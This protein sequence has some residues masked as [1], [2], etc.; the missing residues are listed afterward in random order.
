M[1]PFDRVRDRLP[2]TVGCKW[3]RQR[4]RS[5]GSLRKQHWPRGAMGRIW[6]VHA[7]ER[8]LPVTSKGYGSLALPYRDTDVGRESGPQ[9]NGTW[10]SAWEPIVPLSNGGGGRRYHPRYQVPT[11]YKLPFN[12]CNYRWN[13]KSSHRKGPHPGRT[14][15][16]HV[17]TTL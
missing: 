11:Q 13:L 10:G 9:Q 2:L 12:E 7:C 16:P 17:S 3:C 8:R 6:R 5:C 14:C 4:R 15:P 1:S